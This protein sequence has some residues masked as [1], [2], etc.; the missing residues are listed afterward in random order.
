MALIVKPVKPSVG[1]ISVFGADGGGGGV[2]ISFYFVLIYSFV[3]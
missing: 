3:S 2:G 1:F